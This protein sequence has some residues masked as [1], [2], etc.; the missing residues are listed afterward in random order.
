M[1]E[2][3]PWAWWPGRGSVDLTAQSWQQI[4]RD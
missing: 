1:I 3:F 4:L 2:S